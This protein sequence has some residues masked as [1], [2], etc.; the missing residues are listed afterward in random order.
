[1]SRE[2]ILNSESHLNYE[3]LQVPETT[4]RRL[5]VVGCSSYAGKST[6]VTALC[7]IFSNMGIDVVPF[8]AQNMSLNS[9][10][11]D[12]GGEMGIAQAIQARAARLEPSVHMNPILLK[13]KGNMMSQVIVHGKPYADCEAGGLIGTREIL[14]CVIES[15]RR[16]SNHEL[17]IIEGVGGAAEINLYSR[18]IANIMIARLLKPHLII[19]GDIERGGVFAS[20]YGTWKLLP[21]DVR[22]L[23][24]G[25][26][27]NK[28]RGD[29]KLLGNGPEM[30][31]EMMGIPCLGVIPYTDIRIPSEDSV[32]LDDKKTRGKYPIDVA[33]IRLPRISNFT[34]FEPLEG[35]VN[36]RY[37]PLTSSLGEPDLIVLPGTKNTVGD[38]EELKKSG[39]AKQIVE[40]YRKG[41]PV[42]GICGGYQMLGKQ[43]IDSGVEEKPGVYKGLGLLDITT[44]FEK[45][46][47]TT[48]QTEKRVTGRGAILG[49]IK[50]EKVR[51]Y[52][53]HMGKTHTQKGATQRQA[54][55]DDG[56]ENED[57]LVFGTYLHGLFDNECIRRALIEFLAERKGLKI[58]INVQ[59]THYDP[60]EELAKLVSTHVDVNKILGWCDLNE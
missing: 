30:L 60:Y 28:L 38:L 50:N 6:L 32:S 47:K 40:A 26:V 33:V 15:V 51:G 9:W 12:E 53:I 16:L 25:F 59:N 58:E 52:E 44:T 29:P 46:E 22:N 7:R 55:G 11:T 18:D 49:R 36:V 8:K 17:M 4:Q 45:Y 35:L 19:V 37:V 23:V 3:N 42:I 14:D 54:F 57:G 21:E 5:M 48:V 10:V 34:D 20:I 2:D 13:P 43:I 41:I 31:E 39:M 56:T 1:M 24:K 27:I